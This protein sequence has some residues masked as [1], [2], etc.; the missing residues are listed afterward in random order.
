ME[1]LKYQDVYGVPFGQHGNFKRNFGESGE[2]PADI[3]PTEICVEIE[4]PLHVVDSAAFDSF[5]TMLMGGDRVLILSNHPWAFPGEDGN[6]QERFYMDGAAE[7]NVDTYTSADGSDPAPP[8]DDSGQPADRPEDWF[9]PATHV[10]YVTLR[11]LRLQADETHPP[12]ALHSV[13]KTGDGGEIPPYPQEGGN[14]VE[15]T[16]EGVPGYWQSY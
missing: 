11:R 9:V 10:R 6:I 15:M 13:T 14:L 3:N 1:V 12:L 2:H 7:R 4:G 5:N 16:I 8:R